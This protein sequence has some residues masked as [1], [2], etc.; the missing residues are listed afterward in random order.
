MTFYTHR[1]VNVTDYEVWEHFDNGYSRKVDP[2]L[3]KVGDNF[4]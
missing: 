2:H 3:V 4:A 1:F